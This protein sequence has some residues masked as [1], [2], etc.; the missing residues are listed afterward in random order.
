[1][2]GEISTFLLFFLSEASRSQ[3]WC[4]VVTNIIYYYTQNVYKFSNINSD[5]LI[6]INITQNLLSRCI[7]ASTQ[8]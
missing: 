6:F 8:D 7:V 2:D 1:M 4:M 5:S 3:K